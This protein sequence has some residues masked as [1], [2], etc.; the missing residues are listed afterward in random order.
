MAFVQGQPGQGGPREP[1]RLES[2]G[3]E[4]CDSG[5][6]SL[7]EGQLVQLQEDGGLGGPEGFPGGCPLTSDPRASQ[8]SLEEEEEEEEEGRLDSAL[9]GDEGVGDLVEGV[10]GVHLQSQVGPEAWLRHVLGFVTEDGDTALHLAVI[11][12]H[13]AF[14]D[15][16]LQYTHGTDYLD[17]QNDLGQT[18]LHIA[19]ILGASG[20]VGKLVSAGARLG[21]QEKGGHTAL[22]LACR[23]G[24]RD[25]AEQLLAPLAI[26]RPGQGNRFRAQ[27]DCP[28][29]DGYIPLH[30]AILRKDLGMVSLLISAGSDLNKPELSC[31]RSP[32]HLAVESQSPEVVECLLHAGADTEARM[33]VGYTPMYS[34]VHRP[35]Q[36]IPQLLREFGSEE[37]EWDSEESVDSNSEEEYD[38]IVINCGH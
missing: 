21:V 1:K 10:G 27:L 28:N 9:G 2:G 23:E 16:I 6:G 38:D 14:L 11:H 20:F 31:G 4:W 17:I 15:S 19:V 34:A 18:A 8:K 30:V 5:L 33:Y 25:C 3:E 36:K 32:L 29:Y 37:P 35:D 12:E 24:W 13:E 7:S 22:H 26:Q